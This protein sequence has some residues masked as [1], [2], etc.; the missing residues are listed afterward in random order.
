MTLTTTTGTAEIA[1]QSRIRYRPGHTSYARFTLSAT[2]AG[3]AEEGVKNLNGDKFSIKIS[4][5]AISV[6]RSRAGSAT[7]VSSASFNGDY[8]VSNLTL[9]NI[10]IFEIRWGFLGVAD[11]QFWVFGPNGAGWQVLHTMYTAGTLTTSHVMIPNFRMFASASGAMVAKTISWNGGSYG[12][13]SLAGSR[14]FAHSASATLSGTTI[15]TLAHYVIKPTFN[16]VASPV[17]ARAIRIGFFAGASATGYGT[18]EFKIYA[19]A[20]V[21]G[22]PNQVDINTTSS[23]VA[24]DLDVNYASSGAVVYIDWAGYA[25]ANRA[26]GAGHANFDAAALGLIGHPGDTFTI[27]AQNVEGAEAVTARCT[28]N[29]VEY[30]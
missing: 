9:T 29:W 23:G 15:A 8:S 25:G 10:N 14:A 12:E 21:T 6:L 27:T 11:V 7:E 1:S 30:S 4:N 28:F 3:V 19:N 16:G 18:V 13:N 20:T 22:T 5:G 17:T 2:G 26:A 24:Y